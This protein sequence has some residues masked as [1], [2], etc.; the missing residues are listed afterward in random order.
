MKLI[1]F[2]VA[3]VTYSS[4]SLAQETNNNTSGYG[5]PLIQATNINNDWGLIIGGKGG[6]V[7]NER[8]V[9]G[10]VGQGLVSSMDISTA[11]TSPSLSFE[12]GAG[13][14]YFEYLF[15][16]ESFVGVSI[17][18]NIMAGGVSVNDSETDEEV[19]STGIFIIEPGVN[20]EFKASDYFNPT[21]SISYR[22]T[23]GSSLERLSNQDLSGISIGLIFKFGNY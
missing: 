11:D 3:F 6:G 20:F 13:G 17:P 4:L 21:L 18:L 14:V 9:F 12:Y 19:E 1:F 23:M 5:G 2:L 22:Q 8:F 10:G 15:K 7:F 16:S